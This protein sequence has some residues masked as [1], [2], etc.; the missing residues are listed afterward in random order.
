MKKAQGLQINLIILAALGILVLLIGY[1]LL[2]KGSKAGLTFAEEQ[3]FRVKHQSCQLS[4]K[5]QLLQLESSGQRDLF[6]EIDTDN[7][8]FPDS[9]DYCLGGDD[10][11]LG[12]K[13]IPLACYGGK[14]TLKKSCEAKG[15][16]FNKEITQ[17]VIRK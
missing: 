3:E 16:I 8:G 13:G 14:D 15:G 9:C 7:D 4:G 5:S 1:Q 2:F 17:C 12:E 6:K 11:I 10:R